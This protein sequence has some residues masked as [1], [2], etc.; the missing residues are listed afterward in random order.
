LCCCPEGP[1]LEA[2]TRKHKLAVLVL[3]AVRNDGTA[4]IKGAYH[5]RQAA[6]RGAAALKSRCFM[7]RT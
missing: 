6:V 4:A 7:P 1:K 5:R 2:V 3:V